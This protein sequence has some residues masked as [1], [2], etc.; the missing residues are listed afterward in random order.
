MLLHDLGDIR[1]GHMA[2]KAALGVHY[3]HGAQGAQAKAAGLNDLHLAQQALFLQLPVQL[4]NECLGMGGAAAGT[5][6]H[7]DV[8]S[9]YRHWF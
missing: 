4:I 7:Q 8:C 1:L 3:H 5:A 6:A 9:C 2:V